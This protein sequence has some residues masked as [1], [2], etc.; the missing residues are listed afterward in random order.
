MVSPPVPKR[1]PLT[2]AQQASCAALE[3]E[4]HRALD[5][6]RVASEELQAAAIE[7]APTQL[8]GCLDGGPWG[9]AV[10]GLGAGPCTTGCGQLRWRPAHLDAAGAVARGEEQRDLFTR[11]GLRLTGI[12][13]FDFDGDGEPELF[14]HRTAARVACA[15]PTAVAEGRGDLWAFRGG[16]VVHYPQA[17]PWPARA[18]RD[19]D[20]DGRPDYLTSGPYH[21]ALDP[22]CG[23]SFE[24]AKVIVVDGPELVARSL[25]G[26]AFSFTDV[27]AIDQNRKACPGL[28]VKL[29]L[30]STR[31]ELTL[32][33]TGKNLV[34]AR[35]WGTP[36]A[37]LTAQLRQ[38]R[39]ALCPGAGPC[40]ALDLLLGW[41]ALE[42]PFLF[43]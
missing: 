32:D 26:G 38:E 42:P 18:L 23:R 6:S 9:L 33:R 2:A 1:K 16:A 8:G 13:L 39:A 3:D 5:R 15:T 22:P 12:G 40:P 7:G 24:A 21:A 37:D 20:G 11:T 25:P 35:L 41:A 34:C 30:V 19:A 27:A 28:P 31:P 43:P 36:P 10:E 4:A 14:L 29:V 17:P